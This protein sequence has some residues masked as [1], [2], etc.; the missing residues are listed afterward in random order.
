MLIV[1]PS[2]ATSYMIDAASVGPGGR[3]VRCARCRTTW[4][5]G[6]PKAAP[7][8]TAFVDNVIAEAEAQSTAAPPAPPPAPDEA[9]TAADDFGTESSEPVTEAESPS[10]EPA[11]PHTDLVPYGDN[12]PEPVAITDAPSLV[13][14]IEQAPFPTAT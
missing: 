3:T 14:P 13:P 1:C 9:P 6:G 7:E 4:F 8:V 2:C 11:T 5:A 12:T 10:A